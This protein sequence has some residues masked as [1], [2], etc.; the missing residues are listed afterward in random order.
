MLRGLS[1]VRRRAEQLATRAGAGRCNGNHRMHRVVHVSNENPSRSL[2]QLHYLAELV[3]LVQDCSVME[4]MH[5]TNS[6]RVLP[7]CPTG[8]VGRTAADVARRNGAG[9]PVST[10]LLLGIG[11]A[12]VGVRRYRRM[13]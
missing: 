12:T 7:Q 9:W 6:A 5:A 11:L 4:V 13:R 3:L 10:L 2:Q 8:G 1:N